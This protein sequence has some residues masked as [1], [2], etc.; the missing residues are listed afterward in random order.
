MVHSTSTRVATRCWR[1]AAE[2]AQVNCDHCHH[3]NHVTNSPRRVPR[4]VRS[5]LTSEA[6]WVTA[7]TKTR[8]RN[9]SRLVVWR[10]VV[11]GIS[12]DVIGGREPDQQRRGPQLFVGNVAADLVGKVEAQF[13]ERGVEIVGDGRLHETRA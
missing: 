1:S 11:S 2:P 4:S 10:S 12:G 7:K 3:T 5:W 8:S 9:S 6:I 13:A